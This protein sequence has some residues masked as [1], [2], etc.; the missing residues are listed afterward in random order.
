MIKKWD[1][2]NIGM[3]ANNMTAVINIKIRCKLIL[4][5]WTIQNYYLKLR[6]KETKHYP[7]SQF[8]DR[9]KDL[10]LEKYIRLVKN[11]YNI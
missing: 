10:K 9:I 6:N 5:K 2:K 8:I 3:N 7:T 11:S 1:L 4:I